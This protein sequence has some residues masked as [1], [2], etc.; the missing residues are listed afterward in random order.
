[1]ALFDSILVFENYD[2]NSTLR[3]QGGN[4]LNREFHLIEQTNY[5]L[6][7]AAYSDRELRLLIS[8]DRQRFDDD[9][10]TRMLGHLEVLL[11]GMAA[12]PEQPQTFRYRVLA[13]S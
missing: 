13:N 7:A 9:A 1:M 8:Y 10:I 5:P 11:N 6:T 3:A 2:L 4:W 12:N